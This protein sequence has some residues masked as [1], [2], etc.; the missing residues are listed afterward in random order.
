[1]SIIKFKEPK[2]GYFPSS[3]H[4]VNN[5]NTLESEKLWNLIILSPAVIYRNVALT[6][7]NN[8]KKWKI[9]KEKQKAHLSARQN[10]K[11]SNHAFDPRMSHRWDGL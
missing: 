7:H 2:D 8:A 3:F 1:M 10:R 11:F 5:V 9:G 6:M 4:A